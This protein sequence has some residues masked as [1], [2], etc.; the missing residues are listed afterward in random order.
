MAA[1]RN[2]GHVGPKIQRA[3]RA[4]MKARNLHDIHRSLSEEWEFGFSPVLGATTEDFSCDLTLPE[5]TPGAVRMM[6][7]DCVSYLPDDILCKVDRASMAVGLE[8]RAP[9]LDHELA[10][11]AA[12]IPL[13]MKVRTG[14]GKLIL[15]KLLR[16]YVPAQLVDRPKNGFAIPV[17]DWIKGPL[18]SWAEELLEPRALRADGWFD[19]DL[20][21][22]RWRAH[23]SGAS[24]STAALW[25]VLIFQSWLREEPHMRTCLTPILSDRPDFF[26]RA[27]RPVLV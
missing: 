6:Y 17:G 24:D 19:P 7:S 2:Q 20:V 10:T 18:R 5:R 9:F 21:R 15:R 26:G 27:T 14:Q 1:G 25:A 13:S 23:L 12:R 3:L 4:A 22:A 8:T 11:V 16:K